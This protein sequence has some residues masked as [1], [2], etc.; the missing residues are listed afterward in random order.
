MI[1]IKPVL[2]NFQGGHKTSIDKST[3]MSILS[4]LKT[5]FPMSCNK[6]STRVMCTVDDEMVGTKIFKRDKCVKK[7]VENDKYIVIH[8]NDT[9]RKGIMPCP[10]MYMSAY[11]VKE[12]HIF[13]MNPFVTIVIEEQIH[14]SDDIIYTVCCHLSKESYIDQAADCLLRLVRPNYD[15]TV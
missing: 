14:D 10:H 15:S 12:Q 2:C 11:V 8:T 4:S 9:T 13:T 6:E 1:I 7:Y 5:K 3:Y